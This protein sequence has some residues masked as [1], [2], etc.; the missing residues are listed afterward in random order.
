MGIQMMN[1][2][3]ARHCCGYEQESRTAPISFHGIF[4]RF[5]RLLLSQSEMSFK[6]FVPHITPKCCMICKVNAM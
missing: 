1:F 5:V 3:T 6:I 2:R 4:Y